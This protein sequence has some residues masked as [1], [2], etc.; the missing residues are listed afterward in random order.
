MKVY[1]YFLGFIYAGDK[2][3]RA[4]SSDGRKPIG[5]EAASVMGGGRL[6]RVHRYYHTT[7]CTT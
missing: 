3:V 4:A 1:S 5:E 7:V 6:R 2:W